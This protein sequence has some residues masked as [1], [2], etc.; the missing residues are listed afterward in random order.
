MEYL[1]LELVQAILLRV[2][3]S[4]SEFLHLSLVC[5]QWRSII[6]DK[7][8]LNRFFARHFSR[9]LPIQFDEALW[10]D[11]EIFPYQPE[12][13]IIPPRLLSSIILRLHNYNRYTQSIVHWPLTALSSSF[14]LSCW[15]WLPKDTYSLTFDMQPSSAERAYLFLSPSRSLWCVYAHGMQFSGQCQVNSEQWLLLI[16]NCQTSLVCSFWLDGNEYQSKGERTHFHNL[17]RRDDTFVVR[18]YNNWT[19]YRDALIA[20][21]HVF[22]FCLMQYEIQTMIEQ[23][24]SLDQLN[25]GAHIIEKVMTPTD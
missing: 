11:V 17:S 10:T 13:R 7:P 21:L 23:Q 19:T 12:D 4:F 15:I 16:V 8:L 22:P 18:C 5:R 3:C 1:P 25:M 2:D 20:D 6:I 24:T 9:Q 14:T